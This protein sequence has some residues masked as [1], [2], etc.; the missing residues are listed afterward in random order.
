[1]SKGKIRDHCLQ[2]IKDVFVK[3]AN[4]NTFPDIIEKSIY[5]KTIKDAR[6]KMIERTWENRQFKELYKNHYCKIMGNISHNKNASFVMENIINGVWKPEIIITMNP[7]DLYPELWSTILEKNKLRELRIE[8]DAKE[9]NQEGTG[10]FKC[11]KCKKN[12]CS[13]YQMQTRSADEP[14]TTYVTCLNCNNRWKC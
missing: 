2:K 10:M 9:K 4:T 5:N 6:E 3:F 1:M 8:K 7:R 11:G 14:M 12:N 13:Y